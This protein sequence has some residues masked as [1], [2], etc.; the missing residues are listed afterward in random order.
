MSRHILSMAAIGATLLS[1]GCATTAGSTASTFAGLVSNTKLSH[2]TFDGTFIE[3]LN[4]DTVA[5]GHYAF[6][7]AD[8]QKLALT[9]DPASAKGFLG[10]AHARAFLNTGYSRNLVVDE[11]LVKPLEG[12]R[13]RLLAAWGGPAPD[14]KIF[15]SA[16]QDFHGMAFPENF[17]I[18]PIS[19]LIGIASTESEVNGQKNEIGT[20]DELAA[21]LAHEMSHILLGHYQRSEQASM[22]QKLNNS[23]ASMT[24]IGIMLS[25]LEMQGS[26]DNRTIGLADE[27]RSAGMVEKVLLAEALFTESNRLLSASASRE[28]EDHAD[29]MAMD[30]VV[31]AGYSPEAMPNFL[32]RTSLRQQAAAARLE[33]MNKQQQLLASKVAQTVGAGQ[34]NF[35]T[36]LAFSVGLN[37]VNN[38]MSDASAS[39]RSTD[40][41]KE[42]TSGY[43]ERLTTAV[44][45]SAA[46]ITEGA[47]GSYYQFIMGEVAEAP[48]KGSYI[49][50]LRQGRAAALLDAYKNAFDANKKI[51]ADTEESLEQARELLSAA[52]A[53]GPNEPHILLIASNYNKAVRKTRTAVELLELAVQQ[54]GSGPLN[55]GELADAYYNDGDF[56]KM[57]LAIERGETETQTEV[58]FLH[59]RIAYLE[60][61]GK[62]AEAVA[63]NEKCKKTE[64]ENYIA[65]CATAM[66]RVNAELERRRKEQ[67]AQNPLNGLLGRQN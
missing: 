24:N 67:A 18:V 58:P 10:V 3:T 19:A 49:A 32:T 1:S 41:R 36:D 47:T 21:F 23:A 39:H 38:W 46:P 31:K 17:I 44:T 62:L 9:G 12:V 61:Q 16:D 50:A 6:S 51:T 55:F 8:I 63:A 57:L 25:G 60:S 20:E 59:L 43:L 13:D 29:L 22:R 48:G 14:I 30:L 42:N 15:I 5:A 26:G 66:T 54:P 7:E 37:A 45:S 64:A 53:V 52:L 27:Q 65:K 2:T 40:K 11:S 35:V 4:M 28:Q 33:D 56:P 34:G